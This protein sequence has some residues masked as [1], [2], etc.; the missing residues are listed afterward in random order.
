M[1]I[2]SW[3]TRAADS[4]SQLRLGS[5]FS[6]ISSSTAYALGDSRENTVTAMSLASESTGDA[7]RKSYRK[8]IRALGNSATNTSRFLKTGRKP[9]APGTPERQ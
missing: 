8:T 2:A 4:T 6:P 5:T 9:K 3:S 7:I 1:S